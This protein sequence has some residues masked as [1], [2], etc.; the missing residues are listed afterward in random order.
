MKAG[1]S[2]APTTLV[3]VRPLPGICVCFCT[4][5]NM[6]WAV[7]NPSRMPGMSRMCSE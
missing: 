6:R 7:I 1:Y 5:I 4:H 2:G 3:F